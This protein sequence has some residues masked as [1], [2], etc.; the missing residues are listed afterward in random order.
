[1]RIQFTD[2][3]GTYTVER[4]TLGCTLPEIMEE[5]VIPVLLAAGFQPDTIDGYLNPEK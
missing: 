3:F 1:M 2:D 4:L 5:L